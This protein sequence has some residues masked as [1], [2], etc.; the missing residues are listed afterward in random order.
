MTEKSDCKALQKRIRE[1]EKE[2]SYLSLFKFGLDNMPNSRFAIGN[3]E[4]RFEAVNKGYLNA[5]DKRED[6][7]VGRPAN[8]VVGE[9]MFQTIVKPHFDRALN[10]ECV[11]YSTWFELPNSKK[12]FL[13]IHYYP[14]PRGEEIY[15]V[16]ILIQ[17]LTEI[18]QAEKSLIESEAN[19][20]KVQQIAHMGNWSLDIKQDRIFCSDEFY[21]ILGLTP[22]SF[23]PTYDG[24]LKCVHPEDHR[25]FHSFAKKIKKTAPYSKKYRIIRPDGT[26]RMIHELGEVTVDSAGNPTNIFG[27]IQDI[28]EQVQAEEQY[29]TIIKTAIDGFCLA[30]KQGVL[31]EVNDEYCRM[32]G[33]TREELLQLKVSD[34]DSA[35]TSE[36]TIRQCSIAINKGQCG[37]ETK[38]R[39]KDGTL[40]DVEINIQYSNIKNGVFIGFIRDITEKKKTRE[41][42]MKSEKRFR[43]LFEEAPMMYVVMENQKGL[44]IITDCNHTFLSTLKYNK[45][46]VL[47]KPIT[48]FY[49]EDSNKKTILENGFQC[50]MEKKFTISERELIGHGG[51]IFQTLIQAV[52]E[53]DGLEKITG[54]LAMYSDISFQKRAEEELKENHKVLLMIFDGISDPLI[55]V[56]KKMTLI[57]MNRA[58]EKYF[59]KN[60]DN[61]LTR[62]CHHLFKMRLNPCDGCRVDQAIHTGQKQSFERKGFMNPENLE[63]VAIYPI[64]KKGHDPWAAIVRISDI[65]I[66][67]QME[68]ELIQ[69]DKMISLGILVS[70]V[71]HEINNPNNFIMLNTPILRETWECIVPLIEKYYNE[72]GDFSLA[73]LPYSQMRNEVPL[74]FSGI[75]HGAVCIQRIVQDLKYFSQQSDNNMDQPVNI[76]HLIK[77]SIRLAENLIKANTEKFKIEYSK[78]LPIIKGNRQK[79]GQVMVNLIENACQAL[80][81]KEKGI[82]IISSF[83]EKTGTIVIEV[84]DEGVGISPEI[85]DRIMDPFFTTKRGVGGTG[86]GLAVSSNTVKAHGGRIEVVSELEKGSVFRIVIPIRNLKNSIKILVVNDDFDMRELLLMALKKFECYCV[87]DV[88]NVKDA[89]FKIR[90]EMPDLVILDTQLPDMGCLKICRL[91]RQTSEL[92]NIKVIIITGFHRPS[93]FDEIIKLGFDNILV[94]PF[95]LAVL[96]KI[97]N[98]TLEVEQ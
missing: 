90:E 94:K 21:R 71:A 93:N 23:L 8:E 77:D 4:Y 40:V 27:T 49:T 17:D 58:A 11:N 43:N 63:Q 66:S 73:G 14:I 42:L 80:P 79:L 9:K 24:Y 62:K 5:L 2:N 47:G 95:A 76:N 81:D 13:N 52:P 6:E 51:R 87:R 67:K 84:R 57:L 48:E 20:A 59:E 68:R 37:F 22:E 50:A 98:K 45:A 16:A 64:F 97:I 38:H 12:S 10:G 29:Q 46:D 25:L 1:L 96:Q 33:Y 88:G 85:I 41:A 7:I 28:T 61:C 83:N 34:I 26:I 56:D 70:G 35:R 86:L 74:L 53:Y 19:C 60:N 44:P 75:E 78:D 15:R 89:L 55:M 65:T 32:L 39:C 72:H 54:I 36:E 18:K 91:L 30:D 3:R 92:S 31:L 69:A 82:S